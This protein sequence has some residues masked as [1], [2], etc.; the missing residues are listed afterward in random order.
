MYGHKCSIAM[1]PFAGLI[2]VIFNPCLNWV[3]GSIG[4]AS[5]IAQRKV[6]QPQLSMKAHA[7]SFQTHYW[8]T[9]KEYW[10]MFWKNVALITSWIFMSWAVGPI[11]SFTIYLISASLAAGAGIVLFTVQHNF[12][13]SYASDSR[14]WD[15]ETG[16]IEGTSFL[17]LP[18][19]IN[20]FTANIAYHHIHHLSAKMPNY[21]L[22]R[23][24]NEYCHLFARVTR[25]KFSQIHK[26]LKYILWDT[27]AQRIISVAEHR[28]RVAQAFIA[29]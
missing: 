12:E 25:V 1:A 2:Y 28:Q 29:S 27:R 13:H 22:I 23:C 10:H 3:W 15:Y 24:H 6:A 16:A 5:H 26:S 8:K 11:L 20:W 21:R 4:L 19:W 7:A 9:N 18:R 14:R 17:I